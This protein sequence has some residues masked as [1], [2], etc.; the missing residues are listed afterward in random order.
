MTNTTDPADGADARADAHAEVRN[1]LV[2]AEH[3]RIPWIVALLDRARWT[4]STAVSV[5]E[6][7]YTVLHEVPH[8]LLLTFHL[9]DERGDVALFRILAQYPHLCHRTLVLTTSPEE[10]NRAHQLG[11]PALSA[12]CS[13]RELAA[14]IDQ[15]LATS[16]HHPTLPETPSLHES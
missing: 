7:I 10:T 16:H 12:T 14:A 6:A 11:H 3:Q 15:L 2:I 5:R 13:A 1:V 9:P 8:L 4:V